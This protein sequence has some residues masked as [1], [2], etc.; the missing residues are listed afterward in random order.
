MCAYVC[1]CVRCA[2]HRHLRALRDVVGVQ[3]LPRAC[4]HGAV[5]VKALLG[6]RSGKITWDS[7]VADSNLDMRGGR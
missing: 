1:V 3:R 5:P 2:I 4:S 7:V 6:G